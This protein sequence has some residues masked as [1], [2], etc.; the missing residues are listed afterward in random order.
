MWT[1][2]YLVS[3]NNGKCLREY[4]VS[5]LT[6]MEYQL[7]LE[8]WNT[9]F[10]EGS[11]CGI[12]LILSTIVYQLYSQLMRTDGKQRE[13]FRNLLHIQ[14]QPC[15]AASLIGHLWMMYWQECL[16]LTARTFV[17]Q[18]LLFPLTIQWILL[19]C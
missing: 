3:L 10:T 18:S 19:C 16:I 17:Q 15:L 2:L 7:F 14:T 12:K 4:N 13:G 9:I 6:V 5:F 8:I 1:V 11:F